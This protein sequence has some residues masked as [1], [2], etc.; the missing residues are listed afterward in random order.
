MGGSE[1]FVDELSG[2]SAA[3]IAAALDTLGSTSNDEDE[4][5]AAEDKNNR[6]SMF[7]NDCCGCSSDENS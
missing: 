4:T 6:R 2:V 1:S 7:D 5:M 3:A